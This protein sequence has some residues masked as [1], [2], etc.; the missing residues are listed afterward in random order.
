MRQ[1]YLVD[2]QIYEYSLLQ[3]QKNEYIY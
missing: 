3:D 2:L 1:K